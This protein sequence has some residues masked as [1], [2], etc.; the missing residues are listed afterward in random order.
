[1]ATQPC[2]SELVVRQNLMAGGVGWR[3]AAYLTAAEK[4]R[5]RQEEARD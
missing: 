4:P 1:M 5:K 3:R 2:V